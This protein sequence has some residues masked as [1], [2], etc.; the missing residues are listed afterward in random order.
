MADLSLRGVYVYWSGE[1]KEGLFTWD[2]DCT[3]IGGVG[4]VWRGAERL[5]VDPFGHSGEVLLD[6]L[7]ERETGLRFSIFTRGI[8]FRYGSLDSKCFSYQ[9]YSVERL[10]VIF[11]HRQRRKKRKS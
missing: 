1:T 5:G 11:I 9:E 8:Q 7:E 2:K 3:E 4:A 6:I 10:E